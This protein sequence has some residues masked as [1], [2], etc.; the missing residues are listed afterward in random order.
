[1]GFI[2]GMMMDLHN[3][4]LQV[5]VSGYGEGKWYEATDI[6]VE[7]KAV[8]IYDPDKD[9]EIRFFERDQLIRYRGKEITR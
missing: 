2:G 5:Q 8:T 4:V 7:L 6:D 9:E 1:M 3:Y